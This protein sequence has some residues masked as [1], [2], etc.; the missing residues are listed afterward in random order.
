MVSEEEHQSAID[1]IEAYKNQFV[2]LTKDD[3]FFV[4]MNFK[5]ELNGYKTECVVTELNKKEYNFDGD[6][7]TATL[8]TF[9]G[10]YKSMSPLTSSIQE[11]KSTWSLA[12]GQ[13]FAADGVWAKDREMSDFR[14]KKLESVLKH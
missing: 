7:F 9:D 3:T 14:N 11:Y 4:G 6:P 10:T 1:T 12:R 13:I 8:I 5:C 2:K